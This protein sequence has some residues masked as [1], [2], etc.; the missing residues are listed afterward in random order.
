MQMSHV[1][2]E[3]ALL[4]M[5]NRP[6]VDLKTL[7][8]ILSYLILSQPILSHPTV[9]HPILSQG[10]CHVPQRKGAHETLLEVADELL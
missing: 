4:E 5:A 9:S 6:V 7:R 1:T 3:K 2:R 8:A 10:Q